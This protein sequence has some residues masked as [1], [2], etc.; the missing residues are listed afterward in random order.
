MPTLLTL[1]G[2]EADRRF[3]E[4]QLAATPDNPWGTER[5]MWRNR[6]AEID[7]QLA[8]LR[9]DRSRCASVA[10]IFNGNP[11]IG[12]TDIR[13]DFTADALDRYQKI[14]S[15]VLASK[16]ADELPSRGPLP[17]ADRSRLFIRDLVRG[18]MGFILEEMVPEQ[19][20]LL[21]T[22]LKDAVEHTTELIGALNSESEEEFEVALE[23]IPA[24]L[25]TAVQQFA[26]VLS[27]AGAGTR[28]VGDERSLALSIDEIGKLAR[29][30]GEIETVEEPLAVSG[31]LMGVLPESH[32]FELRAFGGDEETIKGAITEDLAVKYTNDT[33]FK[34]QLLLKPVRAQLKALRTMRNGRLVRQRLILEAL[35]PLSAPGTATAT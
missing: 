21:P 27:D 20:E 8:A 28:I 12:S 13:L 18:S 17:G 3:V 15:V 9:D 19:T 22:P 7:S 32:E 5:L 24:R 35:E 23:S 29:R 10:L 2:L 6:L 34:E 11:V 16:L 26:K 30:L 1:E 4:Q 25:V 33:E 14:V 31:T